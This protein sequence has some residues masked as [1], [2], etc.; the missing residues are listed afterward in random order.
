MDPTQDKQTP[1]DEV[2]NQAIENALNAVKAD[3]PVRVPEELDIAKFAL[4]K[5][6]SWLGL[7]DGGDMP[8]H[9]LVCNGFPDKVGL[10]PDAVDHKVWHVDAD[11]NPLLGLSGVE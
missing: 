1:S 11:T 10:S 4:S 9:R 8:M 6:G 3:N 2:A 5:E 7:T